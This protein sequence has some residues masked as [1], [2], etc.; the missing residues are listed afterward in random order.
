MIILTNEESPIDKFAN[1]L[2]QIPQPI[3]QNLLPLFTQ[4]AQK[5]VQQ[6]QMQEQQQKMQA[7]AQS[8]VQMDM[9]RQQARNEIENYNND[10]I[11]NNETTYMPQ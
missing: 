6:A 10:I 9:Y 7:Q 1:S 2:K 4:E 8:Q 11:N 5:A 3:L